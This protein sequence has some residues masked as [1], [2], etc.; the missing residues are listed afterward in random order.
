[1]RSP[2]AYTPRRGPVGDA[3]PGAA[4]V[5][6]LAPAVVALI[7]PNPAVIAGA[8]LA[9]ALA[10]I[11]AGAQRALAVALRLGLILAV[12]IIVINALLTR[13]GETVLLRGWDVPGFGPIDVTLESVVA[14]GVIGLRIL[15]VTAALAV[16]SASVDPD[17]VLR[18]LR[19]LARHSALT[20][21]LTARLVPLAVADRARLAEA[22]ASRGPAAA[23]LGRAAMVRRL[24]AGSLDRSVDLAA[25]LELRGVSRREKPVWA[26]NRRGTLD[27][28]MI[29]CGALIL[30]A[31]F[32]GGLGGF[33]TYPAIVFGLSTASGIGL[34]AIPA[35]A[36][37]PFAV[38]HLRRRRIRSRVAVVEVAGV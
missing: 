9:V 13:R 6:L 14:G 34:A 7:H 1:M 18:A 17:R 26:A 5:F 12:L 28:L 19:P 38:D 30:V 3:A 37:A 36:M 33:E 32:A 2:L 20:A 21:G 22:S 16:Y 11:G 23:P 15:V 24:A 27:P 25:T 31:G 29:A 10:G 4:V 8:G 35:L